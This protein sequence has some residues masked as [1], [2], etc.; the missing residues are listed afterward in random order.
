MSIAIRWGLSFHHYGLKHKNFYTPAGGRPTN[1]VIVAI[2]REL[3]AFVWAIATTTP[4][5]STKAA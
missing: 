4:I 2:A 3:A 5:T 1:I